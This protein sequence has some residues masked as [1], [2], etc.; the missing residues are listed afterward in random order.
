MREAVSAIRGKQRRR[1]GGGRARTR[2]WGFGD[3]KVQRE[4]TQR[5]LELEINEACGRV[6]SLAEDPV[7][8]W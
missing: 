8:K 2:P 4:R 5:K 6:V 7:G 3:R 1:A